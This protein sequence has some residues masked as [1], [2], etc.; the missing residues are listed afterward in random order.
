MVASTDGVFDFK[1]GNG[2]P[3]RTH[4]GSSFA[5][6]VVNERLLHHEHDLSIPL[7]K[8][9]L[10]SLDLLQLTTPCLPASRPLFLPGMIILRSLITFAPPPFSVLFCLTSVFRLGSHPNNNTTSIPVHGIRS[11]LSRSECSATLFCMFNT[12]FF[13][14]YVGPRARSITRVY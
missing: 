9:G 11:D 3:L 13:S 5:P 7:V 4:S 14:F 12:L 6:S 2:A 1:Q 8:P 10:Q